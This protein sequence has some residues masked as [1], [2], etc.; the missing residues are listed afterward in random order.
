MVSKQTANT[1]GVDT[2][3]LGVDTST[4]RTDGTKTN[5]PDNGVLFVNSFSCSA[6]GLP[7]PNAWPAPTRSIPTRATLPDPEQLRQLLL[8]P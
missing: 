7:H 1:G 3:N 5:L 4:R 8:R 6:S 2:M